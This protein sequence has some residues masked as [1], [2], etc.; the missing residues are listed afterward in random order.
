[1]LAFGFY[2]NWMVGPSYM[3]DCLESEVIYLSF[4]K[5]AGVS[6]WFID[7]FYF[8][9]TYLAEANFEPTFLPG[10]PTPIIASLIFSKFF[11]SGRP[12]STDTL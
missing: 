8:L 12:S 10:M 3:S 7:S 9:D 1:M 11:S 4:L 5:G 6:P 2:L